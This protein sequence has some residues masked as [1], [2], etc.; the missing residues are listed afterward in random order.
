MDCL[1]NINSETKQINISTNNNSNIFQFSR[2]EQLKTEE[3]IEFEENK[4]QNNFS[5]SLNFEE[6][7][8]GNGVENRELNGIEEENVYNT[9]NNYIL[10]QNFQGE[11]DNQQKQSSRPSS[12]SFCWPKEECSTTTINTLDAGDDLPPNEE[13]LG[14][15]VHEIRCGLL[16]GKLHMIRFTCPGIHRKCV[17]FDG[18]LISPRQFTIKAEK[19]KQ[20]DWK[21]SIRLGKHNLRTL[22]EMKTLDFYEHETNCS[23]KCQSRN[24]IKNRKE[25]NGINNEMTIINNNTNN[26]DNNINGG[27]N[28]LIEINDSIKSIPSSSA[29]SSATSTRKS[30]TVLEEFVCQT[31]PP[32]YSSDTQNN[33]LNNFDYL[34]EIKEENTEMTQKLLFSSSPTTIIPSTSSTVFSSSNIIPSSNELINSNNLKQQKIKGGGGESSSSRINLEGINKTNNKSTP[35]PPLENNLTSQETALALLL[36]SIQ[37]SI[38]LE[39]QQKVVNQQQNNNILTQLLSTLNNCGGS[40]GNGGGGGITNSGI[41]LPTNS[42]LFTNKNLLNG[43]NN[44][45]GIEKL[46]AAA[47]LFPQLQQQ[48]QQ[49]TPLKYSEQS[50]VISN[51]TNI[52]KN[53]EENSVMFWSQMRN[54]GLLDDMLKTLSDTLERLKQIYLTGGNAVSEEF[55][56][57]RLSGVALALDLCSLFGEK[58]HSRYIQATLESTLISKELLELQRKQDEQKRKLENAKRKSQ[59]FDQILKNGGTTT[60]LISNHSSSST[61]NNENGTPEIKKLHLNI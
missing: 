1:D 31:V 49:K 13:L 15:P 8:N 37:T 51:L 30:S 5:E 50:T 34:N 54:M 6:N 27:F 16:T 44:N 21:G 43:N 24:Y 47:A 26:N 61:K 7:I 52:R 4:K 39:Q 38:I 58:I 48:Q 56:A 23:L 57:K 28:E 36:Q 35:I 19:D 18:K 59:V 22:M 2:N 33:Q 12:S 29:C 53:M 11:F 42:S 45:N 17:E 25:G 46:L 41:L 9:N 14:A 60:T 10:Q 3:F 40:N 20:K 32:I 55:A